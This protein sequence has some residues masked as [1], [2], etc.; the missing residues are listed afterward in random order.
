MAAAQAEGV[1]FCPNCGA[2]WQTVDAPVTNTSAPPDPFAIEADGAPAVDLA[3][4]DL[5]A[6]PTPLPPPRVTGQVPVLGPPGLDAAPTPTAEPPRAPY[7][8]VTIGLVLGLAGTIV[9]ALMWDR[10]F[11][12]PTV[13]RPAPVVIVRTIDA[14]PEEVVEVEPME[15]PTPSPAVKKPDLAARAAKQ[16]KAVRE[17]I[18]LRF[19]DA[20]PGV[21]V[22]VD[23]K[24]VDDIAY[25]KGEVDSQA[26]REI[27]A[28]AAGKVFGIK[29]VD[30]RE[31]RVVYRQHVIAAGD[32]LGKLAAYYYGDSGKW[33]RIEEANP[34]LTSTTRL[35]LGETL[36]IP[37]DE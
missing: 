35:Q 26:R 4:G 12:P 6:E 7:G 20:P 31:V 5:V 2:D 21:R 8:P 16:G 28:A 29:A 30:A 1:R 22:K 17:A 32:T 36:N 25:L 33:R 24:V 11:P 15:A 19:K 13:A 9:V 27:A 23:V 10:I 18:Q 34:Q 37:M 14:G 3:V